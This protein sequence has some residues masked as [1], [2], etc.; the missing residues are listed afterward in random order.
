VDFREIEKKFVFIRAFAVFR[1]R[2]KLPPDFLR[3]ACAGKL[4]SEIAGPLFKLKLNAHCHPFLTLHQDKLYYQQLACQ[5]WY[6]RG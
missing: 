6:W 3:F 4:C 5:G 1:N 2:F